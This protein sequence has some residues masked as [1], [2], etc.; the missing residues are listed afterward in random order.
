MGIAIEE[1]LVSQAAIK[2]GCNILKAPFSY[3]GIKVGG[4]MSRI[5]AWDDIVEKLQARLSKWKMNTLS[6]GGVRHK[7]FIRADHS[8]KEKKMAWFK[9]SRVLSSKEKGGLG[10]ASLFAL[11]RAL[12]FKWIGGFHNDKNTIW[13]RFICALYGN[14]G[15]INKRLKGRLYA[16]ETDKKISVAD[17]LN[18]NVVASTLRRSP[19]NGVEMEQYS[20]LAEKSSDVERVCAHDSKDT[21]L[22]VSRYPCSKFLEKQNASLMIPKYKEKCTYPPSKVELECEVENEVECGVVVRGGA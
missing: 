4:S 16:L 7:F 11:N 22:M 18:Q 3:L 15:G 12:L 8:K 1:E 13:A 5:K 6:V 17:K 14:S 9:W 21:Y 2:L 20:A 19:R 10:V